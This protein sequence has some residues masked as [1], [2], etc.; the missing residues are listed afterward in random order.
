M[1]GG[2]LKSLSENQAKPAIPPKFPSHR[3]WNRSYGVRELG[4][5]LTAFEVT[6]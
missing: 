2:H 5:Q 3:G 6:K 1:D 4:V